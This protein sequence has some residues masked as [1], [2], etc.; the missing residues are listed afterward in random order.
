[1]AEVSDATS[2][3]SKDKESVNLDRPGAMSPG[4]VKRGI[5]SAIQREAVCRKNKGKCGKFIAPSILG[6]NVLFP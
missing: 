3:A 2:V 6:Q 1:M 4:T 5:V